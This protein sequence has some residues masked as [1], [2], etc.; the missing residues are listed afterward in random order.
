MHERATWILGLLSQIFASFLQLDA[1][2]VVLLGAVVALAIVSLVEV[3]VEWLQN[4][5]GQDAAIREVEK[6]LPLELAIDF[7]GSENGRLLV[8]S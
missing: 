8:A 3:I 7:S 5:S 6:L 2:V 1:D 4:A